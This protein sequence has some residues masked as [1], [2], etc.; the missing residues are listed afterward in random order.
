[1]LYCH[2]R[3]ALPR[4][5]TGAIGGAN[6]VHHTGTVGRDPFAL[7]LGET[8]SFKLLEIAGGFV[9]RFLTTNVGHHVGGIVE[10]VGA[11]VFVGVANDATLA[12]DRRI[13]GHGN[14]VFAEDWFSRGG[15][16]ATKGIVDIPR[17]EL[18]VVNRENLHGLYIGGDG[19]GETIAS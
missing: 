19:P 16:G 2:P 18:V 13:H 3:D 6:I 17:G 5:V 1:M 10:D 14:H 9:P 7:F 15:V 11:F 12:I 4:T 8:G